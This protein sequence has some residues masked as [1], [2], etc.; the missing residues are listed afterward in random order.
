MAQRNGLQNK[1][2]YHA[3]EHKVLQR[4]FTNMQHTKLNI[5]DEFQL[6]T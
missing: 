1:R 6:N 4:T 2:Q 3:K 5:R